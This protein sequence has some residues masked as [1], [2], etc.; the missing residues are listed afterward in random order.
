MRDNEWRRTFV[1]RRR[2]GARQTT[3]RLVC[4]T[5]GL[6]VEKPCEPNY[7]A[8]IAK[9]NQG[10]KNG[11]LGKALFLKTLKQVLLGKWQ[12]ANDGWRA[13]REACVTFFAILEH[14]KHFI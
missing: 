12:Q 8:I 4:V 13:D 10:F 9:E 2:D 11:F 3:D 7:V 1:A 5:A 6:L 14:K